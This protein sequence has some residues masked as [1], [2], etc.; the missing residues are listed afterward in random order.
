MEI[1][2]SEPPK[3]SAVENNQLRF[4]YLRIKFIYLDC[5][6]ILRSLLF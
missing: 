4:F 6:R 1:T 5:D 2:G 3:K